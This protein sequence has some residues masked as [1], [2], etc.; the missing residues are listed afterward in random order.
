M[1]TLEEAQA[2]ARI[3]ADAFGDE[4]VGVHNDT[5][6]VGYYAHHTPEQNRCE[7]LIANRLAET[8]R[9]SIQSHPGQSLQHR[10]S[11]FA[12]SHGAWITSLAL[13]KLSVDERG[14]VNVYTFGGVTMIP[15]RMARDVQIYINE[16]DVIGRGGNFAYD[17]EGILETH[18]KITNRMKKDGSSLRD[19]IKAQFIE[20]K[21]NALEPMRP[22]LSANLANRQLKIEE[23]GRTFFSGQAGDAARIKAELN[24]YM[25]C[26]TDYNIHVLEAPRKERGSSTSLNPDEMAEEVA[27]EMTRHALDSDVQC[28]RLNTFAGVIR[29]IAKSAS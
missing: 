26:I 15:K 7:D 4:V 5:K 8:I 28:H 22:A 2:Q 19:A 9:S 27:L 23:Y 21:Y 1:A 12:H 29:E 25:R 20:D 24:D 16:G 14:Q 6:V 13:D 11:L 3:I 17:P 10:V 18:L